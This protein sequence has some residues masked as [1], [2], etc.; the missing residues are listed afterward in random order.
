M[1]ASECKRKSV[2]DSSDY[3]Q[4]SSSKRIRSTTVSAVHQGK[5]HI[6]RYCIPLLSLDDTQVLYTFPFAT[7]TLSQIM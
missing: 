1:D 4:G 3:W 2:Q 6:N 7:S 5:F